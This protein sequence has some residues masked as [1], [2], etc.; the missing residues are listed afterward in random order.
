MR[1]RCLLDEGDARECLRRLL[2]DRRQVARPGGAEEVVAVGVLRGLVGGDWQWL[3]SSRE[4]VAMSAMSFV[5]HWLRYGL[6]HCS[7]LDGVALVVL[8]A[9]GDHED[10]DAGGLRGGRWRVCACRQP[11]LPGCV[12]RAVG[13]EDDALLHA[14]ATGWW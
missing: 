10:L 8:G 5:T 1:A 4:V 2:E 6:P 11:L 7:P 12:G 9:E 14:R 13:H 3:W